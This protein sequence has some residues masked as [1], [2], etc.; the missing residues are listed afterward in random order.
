MALKDHP[1]NGKCSKVTAHQEER[2]ES[3]QISSGNEKSK[4]NNERKTVKKYIETL[5]LLRHRS[6][7]GDIP[8]HSAGLAKIIPAKENILR[9]LYTERNGWKVYKFPVKTQKANK[10]MKEKRLKNTQKLSNFCA[11]VQTQSNMVLGYIWF[12]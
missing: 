7:P 3:I 9:P 4:Q 2:L 1:C 12:G 11:I 5:E 10:T 8:T 6:K